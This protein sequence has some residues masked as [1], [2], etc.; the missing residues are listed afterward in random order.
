MKVFEKIKS[1]SE[2]NGESAAAIAR[3]YGLTQQAISNY[4]TGKNSMPIDF[5]AWYIT[6]HPEIDLYDLFNI[7]QSVVSEPKSAY[8]TFRKKQTVIDRIVAVLEEEL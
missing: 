3:E 5:L 6:K 1:I 4:F 7:Q 2:K 8:K